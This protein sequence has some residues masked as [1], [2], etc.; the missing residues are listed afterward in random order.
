MLFMKSTAASPWSP[1][2]SCCFRCWPLKDACATTRA[3][4]LAIGGHAG[5]APLLFAVVGEAAL[6]TV[7]YTFTRSETTRT[8]YRWT[9]GVLAISLVSAATLFGRDGPMRAG[10]AAGNALE[11]TSPQECKQGVGLLL[12]DLLG[13]DRRIG[14]RMAVA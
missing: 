5:L 14:V 12:S 6:A 10:A 11:G 7:F 3:A 2:A 9:H 1:P 4:R 13:F 8:G